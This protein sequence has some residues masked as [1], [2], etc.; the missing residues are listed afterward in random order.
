MA[1]CH[2]V[3]DDICHA[4]GW[5]LAS[6]HV[7]MSKEAR[8]AAYSEIQKMIGQRIKWARELVEPNRAE[9][10]R[11]MGVDRTTLQKIEDGDRPP[12]VFN[13]MDLAARLRVT[14][15]YILGGSMRGVDGEMAALLAVEHPELVAE[16]EPWGRRNTAIGG[17]TFPS[18]KRPAGRA[19]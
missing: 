3:K 11:A 14:P 10:A 17:D 18:P 19:A 5:H 13:V 9:F 4:T 6:D 16:A 15:N 7:G 8:P 2:R 12:S 1:I